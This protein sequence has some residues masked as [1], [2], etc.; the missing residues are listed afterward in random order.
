[1]SRLDELRALLADVFFADPAE[2][3][4]DASPERIA[5]WD[6][7]SHLNMTVALEER[8]GVALTMDDIMAMQDVGAIRRVLRTHGVAV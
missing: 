5:G 2:F 4:D 1:M 6:S 7:L 3:D 8:F